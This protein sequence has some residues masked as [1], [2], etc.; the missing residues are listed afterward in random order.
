MS[1]RNP[2]GWIGSKVPGGSTGRCTPF[3]PPRST[4]FPSDEKL[5]KS[6][7]YSAL[8]APIGSGAPTCAITMPISPAGTCTH[9]NF[10]TPNIGQSLKRSPGMSSAAW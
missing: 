9:G 8:F 6:V 2:T 10:F 1:T 3:C 7:W 4:K 5:P